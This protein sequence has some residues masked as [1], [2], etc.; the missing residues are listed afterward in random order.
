MI[1]SRSPHIVKDPC[2][3]IVFG[4]QN[5]LTRRDEVE[6]YLSIAGASLSRVERRGDESGGL[7][8]G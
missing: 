5:L 1:S 2:Q 7:T 8:G 3:V 4:F 6:T